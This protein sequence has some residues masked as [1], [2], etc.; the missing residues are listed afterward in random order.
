MQLFWFRLL[1][2]GRV[3]YSPLQK[4]TAPEY[5]SNKP[6]K[7]PRRAPHVG[8]SGPLLSLVTTVLENLITSAMFVTGVDAIKPG[9]K[10][11]AATNLARNRQ[12]PEYLLIGS[13]NCLYDMQSST[14]QA[15]LVKVTSCFG[16]RLP[17]ILLNRI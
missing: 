12:H 4:K 8:L 2:R 9:N 17:I 3:F 15:G 7:A 13:V 5:L 10:P 16:K 14:E 6:L 11:D 1:A